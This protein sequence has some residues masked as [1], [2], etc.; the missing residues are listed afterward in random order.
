MEDNNTEVLYQEEE[1][2][3]MVEYVLLIVLI[4][5]LAIAAIQFA[6][7]SVSQRFSNVGSTVAP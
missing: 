2:A 1:G 3:T 5:I 7:Q 6:G 4:A